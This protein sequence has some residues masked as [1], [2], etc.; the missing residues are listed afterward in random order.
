M[1]FMTPK[2][3]DPELFLVTEEGIEFLSETPVSFL[4]EGKWDIDEDLG[5][6]V[7]SPEELLALVH[8]MKKPGFSR[9]EVVHRYW[10]CLRTVTSTPPV[11]GESR[12]EVAR[13]LKRLANSA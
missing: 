12:E 11:L 10:G 8:F 9:L 6:A 4:P 13:Q 3:H 5:G 1:S 7:S 2:I